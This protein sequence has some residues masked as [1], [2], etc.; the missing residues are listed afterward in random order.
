LERWNEEGL[1]GIKFKWSDG[2]PLKLTKEQ[3]NELKEDMINLELK[4][5]KQIKNHILD[6][7]GVNYAISWLPTVLRSIGA[8]YGKPY[9]INHKEHENAEEI[10]HEQVREIKKELK[11]RKIEEKDII[12]VFMDEGSFQNSDNSQRIWYFSENKIKKNFS[13]KS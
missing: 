11:S 2:R 1:E 6:K 5:T 7:W 8:K 10:I 13:R 4:T 9:M 12:F 3:F